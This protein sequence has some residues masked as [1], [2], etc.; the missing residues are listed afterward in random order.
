[1]ITLAADC[2]VFQLSSGEN[3]PFSSEMISVEMMGPTSEWFDP[4]V[5][6]D[7]AKAVFYYFK[8]EQGRE[9]ISVAEFAEALERV[10]S[11]FEKARTETDSA[12]P[13]VFDSD[14]SQLARE[15]GDCGELVF[16]PRLR[17]EFRQHAQKSP[18]VL[19]FSG[20]RDCVKQLAGT[21]R[22]GARCR[23]VQEQVVT[24]LRECLSAEMRS[25]DCLVVIQ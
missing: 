18:R 25:A 23:T 1:M 5:V 6:K 9:T 17:Q 19:R 4:E 13:G 7:A 12:A 11:G 2:L 14:L 24:Y 10:L 8:H 21:E 3:M 20:L 22:W 16:Y 15:S